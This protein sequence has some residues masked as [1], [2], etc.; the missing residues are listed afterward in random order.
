MKKLA[1]TLAASIGLTSALFSFASTPTP[2]PTPTPNPRKAV[3]QCMQAATAKEAA[4]FKAAKNA[5][6]DAIKN[7]PGKAGK[8]VRAKALADYKAMQKAAKV[9]FAADRKACTAA[10]PKK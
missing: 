1:I 8:A 5:Y 2:R 6:L 7:A 9:A 4:A 3:A 10:A